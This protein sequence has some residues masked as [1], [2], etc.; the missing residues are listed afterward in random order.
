[1]FGHQITTWNAKVL[2]LVLIL[3]CIG[4]STIQATTYC[5][6]QD[7]SPIESQETEKFKLCMYSTQAV[8]SEQI[9]KV[10]ST[11]KNKVTSCLNNKVCFAACN[12]DSCLTLQSAL[13]VIDAKVWLAKIFCCMALSYLLV[14]V[15]IIVALSVKVGFQT[16][17]CSNKIQEIVEKSLESL[18]SD[19][20]SSSSS[21]SNSLQEL[22]TFQRFIYRRSYLQESLLEEQEGASNN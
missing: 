4:K 5:Y 14:S 20:D 16:A 19:P 22:G 8:E 7:L 9:E 12:I 1:M 13:E 3:A 17:K 21:Q 18:S 2:R 10:W 11:S 6:D 15:G